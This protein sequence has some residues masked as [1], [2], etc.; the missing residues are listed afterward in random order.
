MSYREMYCVNSSIISKL[1]VVRVFSDRSCCCS[2]LDPLQRVPV[3]NVDH[4]TLYGDPGLA[5]RRKGA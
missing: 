5:Q 3:V 1:N 4:P 2:G